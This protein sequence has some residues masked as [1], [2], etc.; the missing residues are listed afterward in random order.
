[1]PQASLPI[2]PERLW[3]P[4]SLVL[5]FNCREQVF[6]SLHS[7]ADASSRSF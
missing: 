2:P 1:M 5:S 4:S 7:L 6:L 3:H